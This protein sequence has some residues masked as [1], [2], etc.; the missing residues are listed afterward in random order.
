V[1][2]GAGYL[3]ADADDGRSP[4]FVVS[5]TG[6]GARGS[7]AVFPLDDAGN[8]PMEFTV[9]GLP[10]LAE[11]ET[12]VLWLTRDGRPARSCGTFVVHEGLTIVPLNAPYR[13]R[14]FDGWIVTR[15]GSEE[16][17]LHT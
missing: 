15:E 6:P 8:W 13:L 4:E 5:M 17:L 7:L 14:D 2:F 9:R 11:G 12:Y 10:E 3:V 16:P 1:S